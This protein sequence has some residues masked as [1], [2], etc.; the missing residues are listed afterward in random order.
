MKKLS[1][2]TQTFSKII[3]DKCVYV[4]KTKYLYQLIQGNCYFLSR[5][6]RFG[7]SLLCSTLKDFFLGKKELFNGLWIARHVNYSW[8]VHPVIHID[9][10]LIAHKTAEELSASLMRYLN[11][12]A[13]MYC[14]EKL[15]TTTPGEMLRKLTIA[16]FEKHESKNC[17][18]IIVDEYDKPI[19]EHINN[20]DKANEMREI[21]R[22]FYEFIKGLDEYLRFVFITGVCRFSKTSIFSG[23]NQLNDITMNPQYAHLV[24]YT[25]EEINT[26]FKDHLKQT[27]YNRNMSTKELSTH[28]RILY[29]GYRFWQD[30]PIGLR[31]SSGNELARVYSPI[32]I[33]KFFDTS[34]FENYWFESA[35]PTVLINLLKKNNYSVEEFAQLKASTDELATFEPDDL[36]LATLLFQTGYVTIKSY[37]SVSKNYL[38]EAPNQEVRES[39]FKYI[40]S[41][42]TQYRQSQINDRLQT[43]RHSLEINH[44]DQFIKQLKQFYTEVPYTIAI[45]QEKYYQTIFYVILKLINMNPEV[46]KATNVGRIDTI[47]ETNEVIYIFEFKLNVSAEVAMKQIVDMKYYEPYLERGKTIMLIGVNFSTKEKNIADYVF[48]N[49]ETV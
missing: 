41:L 21:L 9:F 27:A 10:S 19:L 20:P 40:L 38:L 47:I 44:I 2:G 28:L 36:P 31:S 8:S 30:Q 45:N 43:L 29:N 14:V 3:N 15:A 39:L 34:I 7:K 17:V 46:E 42:V 37:D 25:E 4:D 16:L 23:L 22:L 32:S 6:R 5:P 11:D 48:K 13:T 49:L 12:I 35:T 18:V 24:G 33:L 26:F 1:L